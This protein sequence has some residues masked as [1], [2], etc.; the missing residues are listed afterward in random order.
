MVVPTND[1]SAVFL[2]YLYR[3]VC[4]AIVG[5]DNLVYAC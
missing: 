1:F 2:G 4:A 3:S 5:N